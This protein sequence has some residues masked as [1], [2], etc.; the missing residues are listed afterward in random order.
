FDWVRAPAKLLQLISRYRGTLC[1]LPNFAYNF[2]AQKVRPRDLEG[3]SLASMRAFINCSEPTFAESHRMFAERF[4]PLGLRPET[5][6]TS[7]A[8]AENVFAVT[9]SGLDGPTREAARQGASL[10]SAGRPLADVRIRI[11]GENELEKPE[12]E[13]GEIALHSNC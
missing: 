13:V 7:Y 2:M 12:G 5:L 9:Q 4:A 6:T 11:L 1:W 3:V 8:M 10:L